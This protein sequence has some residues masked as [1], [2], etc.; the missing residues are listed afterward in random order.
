MRSKDRG[1]ENKRQSGD[2]NKRGNTK[3]DYPDDQGLTGKE[4]TL[5]FGLSRKEK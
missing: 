1:K 2:P 3:R 5:S 4:S